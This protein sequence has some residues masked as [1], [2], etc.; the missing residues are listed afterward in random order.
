M[1]EISGELVLAGVTGYIGRDFTPGSFLFSMVD[2][3]GDNMALSV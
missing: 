1:F 3:Y 2:V